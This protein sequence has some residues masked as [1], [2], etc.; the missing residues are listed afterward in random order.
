MDLDELLLVPQALHAVEHC[1]H[2]DQ[3]PYCAGGGGGGGL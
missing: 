3:G 1:D 2:S